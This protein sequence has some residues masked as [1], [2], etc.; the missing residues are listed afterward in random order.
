M[1][2]HPAN[3]KAN[4]P[5]ARHAA[6]PHAESRLGT[7]APG[8]HAKPVDSKPQPHH[9][10]RPDLD[11]ASAGTDTDAAPDSTPPSPNTD[12]A[13][14]STTPGPNTDAAFDHATAGEN[15]EPVDVA[16]R[17]DRPH[18]NPFAPDRTVEAVIDTPDDSTRA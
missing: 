4:H 5:K 12:A 3:R 13:S 16:Q 7:A 15:A 9:V 14:N 1:D 8:A 18:A 2:Q 17:S 10:A 6:S 11:H